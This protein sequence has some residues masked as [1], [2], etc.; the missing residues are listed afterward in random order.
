MLEARAPFS[1]IYLNRNRV[2]RAPEH[3]GNF[4]GRGRERSEELRR[5]CRRLGLDPHRVACHD[6]GDLQDGPACD[7]RPESIAQ[8]VGPYVAEYAIN[9]VVTFDLGG[10]SGHPNHCAL[11]AGVRAMLAQW[12]PRA[13]PGKGHR[14][15]PPPLR[16]NALVLETVAGW[17]KYLG[18]CDVLVAWWRHPRRRPA[19][20]GRFSAGSGSGNAEA[21]LSVSPPADVVVALFAMLAHASQLEWYRILFILFSSYTYVNTLRPLNAA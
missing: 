4:Y 5:C 16:P 20:G 1:P 17:R 13:P 19:V 15:T 12:P 18:A 11:P 2:A 21:R 7:W 14:A 6:A 9:C 10:A 3:A 8:V